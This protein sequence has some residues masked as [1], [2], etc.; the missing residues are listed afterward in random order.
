MEQ[1]Q[2]AQGVD[3]ERWHVL[4]HARPLVQEGICYGRY[5]MPADAAATRAAGQ[6]FTRDWINA[7]RGDKA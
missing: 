1:L 3:F 2:M 7:S 4:H 6:A 5:K